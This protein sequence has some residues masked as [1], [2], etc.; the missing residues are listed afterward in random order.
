MSATCERNWPDI[1][2]EPSCIL[3]LT[4]FPRGKT[5]S[6]HFRRK[7]ISQYGVMNESTMLGLNLGVGDRSPIYQTVSEALEKFSN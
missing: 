7:T 2:I 4:H 1:S 6:V 5:S 3:I